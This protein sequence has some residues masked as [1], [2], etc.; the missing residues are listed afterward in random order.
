MNAKMKAGKAKR[1]K[2]PGGILIAAPAE[3][4]KDAGK[5]KRLANLKRGGKK[6]AK[7]KPTLLKE[8]LDKRTRE[9]ADGIVTAPLEVLLDLMLRRYNRFVVLA[10][11]LSQPPKVEVAPSGADPIEFAEKIR[12]ARRDLMGEAEH[13]ENQAGHFAI[14]AAPYCHSKLQTID[15]NV[16][17]NVAISIIS[18]KDAPDVKESE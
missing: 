9:I 13:M 4:S 16:K 11:L 14:A 3:A 6:G 17:R 1:L 7:H 5:A 2:V 18:F 15:K 12:N 10:E 8:A